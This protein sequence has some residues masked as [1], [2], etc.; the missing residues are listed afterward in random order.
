MKYVKLIMALLFITAISFSTDAYAALAKDTD[1]KLATVK[2]L[3]EKEAERV[4]YE[5]FADMPEYK[6]VELKHLYTKVSSVSDNRYFAFCMVKTI[7]SEEQ[8]VVTDFSGAFVKVITDSV[9]NLI[10]ISYDPVPEALLNGEEKET[11]ER[12]LVS[13]EDIIETTEKN[14]PE[15]TT[16]LKDKTAFDYFIA[17]SG[18][19]DDEPDIYPAWFVYYTGKD[20]ED[21][22]VYYARVYKA[23]LND[24]GKVTRSAE[25]RLY[26]EDLVGVTDLNAIAEAYFDTRYVEDA[27]YVS[28]EIDFNK[29]GAEEGSAKSGIH[30]V[31]VPIMKEKATGLYV[32]GSISQRILVTNDSHENRT[33]DGIN[34]L[35]SSQPEKLES[36][37][38]ERE[39]LLS[40]GQKLFCDPEYIM[41]PYYSVCE[42]KRGA[43]NIFELGVENQPLAPLLLNVYSASYGYPQTEDGFDFDLSSYG[44]K[45][46]WNWMNIPYLGRD[47]LL[48]LDTIGH[49]YIHGVTGELASAPY[50]SECGATTEAYADILGNMIEMI[51]ERRADEKDWLLYDTVTAN[52]LGM[53]LSEPHDSNSPRYVGDVFYMPE[54]S[55]ATTK[56]SFDSQY[57]V[58]MDNGGLHINANVLTYLAYQ[59]SNKENVLE[60]E[61]ALTMREN[62]CLWYE[63]AYIRT[64]M[65]DFNDVAFNLSSAARMLGFSKEKIARI[66]R[67]IF[68]HGLAGTKE[69]SER[70]KEL[71]EQY[72]EPVTVHFTSDSEDTIKGR[73][74]GMRCLYDGISGNPI[75]CSED[76]IISSYV[77]KDSEGVLIAMV[78]ID[79]ADLCLYGG[80]YSSISDEIFSDYYAD[81]EEIVL[82]KGD[83]YSF[84]EEIIR[85]RYISN[86]EENYVPETEEGN[87]ITFDRTGYYN[88][89]VHTADMGPNEIR[90]YIIKV[91]SENK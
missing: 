79:S 9:G 3:D 33:L 40:T 38:F 75:I 14:L 65:D 49:E 15:G 7:E 62:A 36:W 17:S 68:D 23:T 37:H 61:A 76:P 25:L 74:V 39:T 24:K 21:R 64:A 4:A 90:V 22:P 43:A 63:T 91:N 87:T 58:N 50:E 16:L 72:A 55:P 8:W 46:G 84:T 51:T 60:N 44:L 13:R 5:Y 73:L 54:G 1:Q 26:S 78:D 32:L 81:I 89:V 70:V 80:Y 11:D 12:I 69:S 47:G 6:G 30:T 77:I 27:G 41:V 45:R 19:V 42:V 86:I 71:I 29:Y 48:G 2:V 67:L 52:G 18:F 57:L 31:T 59:L 83:S 82:S 66:D 34:R 35:V 88:V 56:W 20:E 28:F 10:A 53:S 85:I